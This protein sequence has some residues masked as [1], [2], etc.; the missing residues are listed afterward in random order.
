MGKQNVYDDLEPKIHKR[1]AEAVADAVPVLDIACGEWQVDR[2]R[3]IGIWLQHLWCRY[4]RI[5]S[6]RSPGKGGDSGH[7]A[8]C[9]PRCRECTET[10]LS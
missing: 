3:C 4:L 7:L 5:S 8:S 6:N 1:I 9:A 10:L 2:F